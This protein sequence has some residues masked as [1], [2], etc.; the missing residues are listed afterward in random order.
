MRGRTS[1]LPLASYLGQL[2]RPGSVTRVVTRASRSPFRRAPWCQSSDRASSSCP[3]L[4]VV[5]RQKNERGSTLGVRA[6]EGFGWLLSASCDAVSLAAGRDG[7]RPA[8]GEHEQDCACADPG[9][10]PLKRLVRG[11]RRLVRRRATRSVSHDA[12]RRA[13]PPDTRAATKADSVPPGRLAEVAG[14]RSLVIGIWPHGRAGNE[15]I[16]VSCAG[17]RIRRPAAAS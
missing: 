5:A 17:R 2:R 14:S 8:N 3:G 6:S 13:A 12:I 10:T 11:G 9:V 7:C 4:R 1:R 16:R 15:T